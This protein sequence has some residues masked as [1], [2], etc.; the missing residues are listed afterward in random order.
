MKLYV[1]K[2]PAMP[3]NA[4]ADKCIYTL[5]EIYPKVVSHGNRVGSW[6][7]FLGFFFSKN[8][9][10]ILSRCCVKYLN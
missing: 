9:Q 2:V 7:K 4:Y 8:L 6:V 5:R 3:I 10:K 1:I